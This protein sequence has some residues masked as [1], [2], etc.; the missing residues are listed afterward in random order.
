VCPECGSL[1]QCP[2][3]DDEDDIRNPT[4]S[5]KISEE[6]YEMVANEAIPPYSEVFNTYGEDLSNAQLLLQHGFVL[7]S[8]DNDKITWTVDEILDSLEIDSRNLQKRLLFLMGTWIDSPSFRLTNEECDF[9]SHDVDRL[10]KGCYRGDYFLNADAQISVDLWLCLMT[11]SAL[12]RGE[13]RELCPKWDIEGDTR[14]AIK[15]VYGLLN[16]VHGEILKETEEHGDR[17]M[18]FFFS[19]V[20]KRWYIAHMDVARFVT[21]LCQTRGAKTGKQPCLSNGH[22]EDPIEALDVCS[23][24]NFGGSTLI[25]VS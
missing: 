19:T 21:K 16:L 13:P 3:D 10:R 8:N 1:D 14:L 17:D 23:L 18:G 11:I 25:W 9:I 6:D 2:H 12:Q 15:N 20:D 7:E 4:T 22:T 5:S 24:L